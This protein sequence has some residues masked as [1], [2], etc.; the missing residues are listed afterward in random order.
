LLHPDQLLAISLLE[1]AGALRRLHH[2]AAQHDRTIH[3]FLLSVIRIRFAS[4]LID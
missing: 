2:S 4:Q 3:V 1:V